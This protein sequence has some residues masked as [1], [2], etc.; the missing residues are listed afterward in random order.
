MKWLFLFFSFLLIIPIA[1]ALYGGDSELIHSFDRCDDLNVLVHADFQIDEGE[2]YFDGCSLVE[3][4]LWICECGGNFNLVLGTEVNTVNSYGF[5]I[6]YSLSVVGVEEYENDDERRI[7]IPTEREFINGYTRDLFV[8]D[9]FKITIDSNEYY[10]SLSLREDDEI[11]MRVTGENIDSNFD[12]GRGDRVRFDVNDDGSFDFYVKFYENKGGGAE[13][14]IGKL[15]GVEKS[16]DAVEFV[17]DIVLNENSNSEEKSGL[18]NFLSAITGAVVGTDDVGGF[19]YVFVG[20]IF[21]LVLSGL[22][23]AAMRIGKKK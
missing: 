23:L 16:L 11:K 6:S 19:D 17:E 14:E 1:S 10:I 9:M 20:L 12:L 13:I 5:D 15:L 18:V 7:F 8:G 21:A 4:E 22:I 3:D 2:Y